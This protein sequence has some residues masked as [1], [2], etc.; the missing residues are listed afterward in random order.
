MASSISEAFPAATAS[1]FSTASV[2][3]ARPD[4]STSTTIAPP[5]ILSACVPASWLL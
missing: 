2:A 3:S 5:T 1:G 4:E